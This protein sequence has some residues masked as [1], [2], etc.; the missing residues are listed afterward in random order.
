M[1]AVGVAR[2]PQGLILSLSKDEAVLRDAKFVGNR[3][4]TSV[5]NSKIFVRVFNALR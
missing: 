3:R 4:F 5:G 1:T 2:S